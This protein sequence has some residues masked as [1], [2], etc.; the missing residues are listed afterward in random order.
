MDQ[1]LL[2]ASRYQITS[3]SLDTRFADQF[4]PPSVIY[5][6]DNCLPNTGTADV[7]W[8]MPHKYRNIMRI[9]LSSVE[10]PEV[11]YLFS[12]KN[13]NINFSVSLDG[14][15]PV[16]LTIEA[17][18]YRSTDMAEE[19]QGVLRDAFGSPPT[20]TT[21]FSVGVNT[22]SGKIIITHGSLPFTIWWAS[23]QA[24]I[25]SQRRDWGIGY[26]L[27]FREKIVS[28]TPT[29]T[30]SYE[31][32][33]MAVLRVQPAAYYLLQLLIP[34]PVEAIT[35]RLADGTSIPVF[36]KLVLRENWYHL[37]FDDNSNLLRKEY[38]FLSPVDI[39]NVRMRLLDPYG[40]LVQINDLD[41][42]AT[43]EL[44]EVKNSRTYHAIQQTYARR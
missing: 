19:L 31:M 26:N 41:W 6:Q 13:G 8:R 42:S 15:A 39:S 40:R 37:Q 27:G 2:D 22:I 30:G 25:A 36:A 18:N 7:M 32:T 28:A 20:A 3:M 38:T 9:G 23:D 11:E 10:L 33:A 35:H 29:G 5:S 1:E 4:F 14:T 44:Y 12:A 43:V 21:Y 24:A 16:P 17:G 34:E